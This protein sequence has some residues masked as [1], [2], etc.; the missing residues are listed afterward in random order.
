MNLPLGAA[1][2]AV[3][4]D[5]RQSDTVL[6]DN[7]SAGKGKSI[8]HR[9][10]HGTTTFDFVGKRRYGF[11]L[12]LAMVAISLVSLILVRHLNLG[13]EFEGGVAWEYDAKG[14]S[15]KQADAIVDRFGLREGA[16][17]QTLNSQV[18]TTR[19]RVQVGPLDVAK[20]NEVRTAFAELTKA[21]DNT[22]ELSAVSASWGEEITRKAVKAL[23][24][25]FALLT[26]Y[27]WLRFEWKMAIAAFVAVVHDVLITVGIYS[28][29]GFEVAPA[30]VIAFLTI[31]GFSLYDTIVVF[32][33]VHDNTRRLSN[34]GR[35][36]YGDVVNLSMN[37][38]LMRSINTSLAAMLPVL[39]LLVVGSWLM[40][41][42]SLQDF[43]LALFFGL[44]T[45]S[46]SS[47]FVATPVLA[48]LKERE[49]R[50]RALRDKA[51]RNAEMGGLRTAAAG[52]ASAAVGASGA[53]RAGA[54]PDATGV[55]SAISKVTGSVPPRP[56]KQKRR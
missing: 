6:S 11:A 48:V 41:A 5:P 55:D 18:G 12:S 28:V 32:D 23:L 47:I 31:L 56:R 49:P 29:F 44:L 25:F 13:I 21:P 51:Q 22:V 37:Q 42:R 50:Y 54:R 19:I 35:A 4:L 3:D 24:W 40:G 2:D 34:T 14:T 43:A 15:T 27:I 17:V 16:K 46:Y 36:T 10:Y 45:G 39:S 52:A 33:K 8:W 26:I 20:Q 38:V 7:R 30:T 53:V 1:G 9:L